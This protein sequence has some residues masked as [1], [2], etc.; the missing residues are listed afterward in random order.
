[1][2]NLATLTRGQDGLNKNSLHKRWR[3]A[4]IGLLLLGLAGCSSDGEE[5]IEPK[6][7][8]KI[9]EEVKLKKVWSRGVGDGQGENWLHLMPAAVGDAIYT[10]DIN[11]LVTATN[12]ET[13]K[14]IWKTDLDRKITGGVGAGEGLVLVASRDGHVI[15]LDAETGEKTWEVP[16]S[17]EVLS[18]PQIGYGVVVVQTIDAKLTGLSAI[19]GER[20]WLQEAMLPV[21]TLRGTATPLV[22]DGAVFAGFSNGEAKAFRVDNGSQIWNSRIAI[23]RGTS[24]LERMVDIEAAPLL[25]SGILYMVSYQGNIVALDPASGRIQW[26]R[27]ASSYENLSEGFGHL[28]LV[29]SE[30]TVIGI[31]ERTGSAVWSQQDLQNRRLSATAT[32]DSQVLTGDFE[33]YLHVLSQIDGRIIGRTKVDSSGIRVKPLVFEDMIYVYSNDG[34]LVALKLVDLTAE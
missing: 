14:A 25:A 12:N 7:L 32:I 17:S 19:N 9:T 31:D 13:G 3:T 16:V 33:G 18:A 5:V 26:Q 27:E 4:A 22:V 34:D 28:Y 10:V 6:P 20:L 11:G 21:L 29:D 8:P 15:A 1:M 30:S 24:E 2:L 23:P